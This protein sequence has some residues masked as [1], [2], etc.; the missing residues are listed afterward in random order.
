LTVVLAGAAA[1]VLLTMGL[2][3]PLRRWPSLTA[4]WALF[5]LPSGAF[6]FGVLVTT[7]QLGI[8]YALGLEYRFARGTVTPFSAGLMMVGGL[9]Y[10][11]I[12][13]LLL[14]FAVATMYQ[15]KTVVDDDARLDAA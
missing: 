14:P 12:G 6:V 11:A 8:K 13:L 7:F 15:L 4:L 9:R 2:V 3:W 1:G 5:A 10:Y